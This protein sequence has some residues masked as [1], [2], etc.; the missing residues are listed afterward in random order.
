MYCHVSHIRSFILEEV[1]SYL[2]L[3]IRLNSH[4]G[5]GLPCRAHPKKKPR[6][7]PGLG[8]EE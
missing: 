1:I 5:R 3:N 8:D 6:R 2:L 7:L 4:G